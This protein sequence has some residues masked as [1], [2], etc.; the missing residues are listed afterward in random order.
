MAKQELTAELMA[1]IADRFRVLGEPARLQ[2]LQALRGGELTVGELVEETGLTTGN[3]SKHLQML[4][5]A[6]FVTR[7]KEGLHVYYG[8]AGEDV[9]KLCDIM[10]GQ[11]QAESESRRRVISGR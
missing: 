9:F 7:R 2:I 6:A 11:L 8:L 5:A 4:Y 1:L 10:C 3:T